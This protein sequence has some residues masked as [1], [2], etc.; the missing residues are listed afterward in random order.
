V[1]K[2]SG[3]RLRA[4]V[5]ARAAVG[6]AVGAASPAIAAG[7]TPSTP[8]KLMDAGENCSTDQTSPPYV[9]ANTGITIEGVPTDTDPSEATLT[10]TYQLWPVDDPSQATI[11]SLSAVA[12]YE[13][14][15]LVPAADLV[16]GETYAWQAETAAVGPLPDPFDGYAGSVAAAA[17]G[18]SATVDLV[19]PMASDYLVLDVESVDR[20][21]N[22]SPVATD[23]VELSS[24]VPAIKLRG[25]LPAFG[26]PNSFKLTP[27]RAIEKQSPVTS[28][29]IQVVGGASGQ[30]NYSSCSPPTTSS[31]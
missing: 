4:A 3:G 13:A 5:V 8:T 20:A 2:P 1:Y 16:N 15:L 11:W 30:Q 10:E 21:Y 14:P 28:Y 9:N 25:S 12:G 29:N 17:L 23:T 27:D 24:S 26:T 18:G 6:L 7:G 22:P 31:P 19:P